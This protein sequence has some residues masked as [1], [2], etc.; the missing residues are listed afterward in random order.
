MGSGFLFYTHFGKNTGT[1]AKQAD[2]HILKCFAYA[3]DKQQSI[4]LLIKFR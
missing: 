3:F 4:V 2:S 1:Q